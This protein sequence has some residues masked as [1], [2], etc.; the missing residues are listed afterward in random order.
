MFS[1][2]ILIG[3]YSYFIFAL[4]IVGLFYKQNIIILTIVYFL[5]VM[6]WFKN[7]LYS[8]LFNCFKTFKQGIRVRRLIKFD[9][10]PKLTIFLLAII[11]MQAFVNL[12]GTLGPEL[13]FDALW[14][15]LTLPKIYLHYHAIFHIKGS[16]FYYSDMPKLAEMLYIAAL[17]FKDEILAKSIHFSF[18]ILTLIALFQLSRRF[19]SQTLSLL[20]LVIFYSNLVVAW[21]STTAY[22]D[23][24]R[25]FFEVMA[26]WGL[27][28]WW[29]KEEKKWLIESAVMLGLAIS[30]KLLA[31]GS[32]VI[33]T[34]LI[35]YKSIPSNRKV[36]LKMITNILV[37]WCCSVGIV[38]PYLVFSFVN[39]GNPVFPFFTSIYPV[40]PAFAGLNPFHFLREVWTLL[41]HADDPLSPVYLISLPLILIYFRRF[42]KE[43][44]VVGIY[45]MLSIIIWYVTPKTGGGRFILPYLPAFSILVIATI[46]VIKEKRMKILLIGCIVF[47]SLVSIIY[48]GFANKRYIPVIVGSQSKAEFLKNNLNFAFGDFYDTDSYFEKKITD[49]DNVLIF[50][51]HNLYYVDFPFIHESYVEKGDTFNY[52]LTQNVD[53]PKRFWYW[54]QIYKNDITDVKLYTL[55]GQEWIY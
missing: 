13:S 17:S 27:L 45:S 4:G 40:R 32:L 26:L 22:V 10:R 54:K 23:L 24:A 52:I 18:G 33:V 15:H 20:V 53:L 6:F 36:F 55:G 48:R 16:L 43:F 3:I 19:F 37:Y 29:K 49:K 1:I 42:M 46:E 41:T 51:V 50:G 8:I 34:I 12:V 25:T 35:M 28:N 47:I 21:E 2:A 44:K 38:L 11:L 30:V 9:G 31:I 5:I 7:Y 14:Y 39:T